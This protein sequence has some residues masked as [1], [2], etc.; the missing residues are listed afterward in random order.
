MVK[1]KTRM[2]V[3]WFKFNTL[4]MVLLQPLMVHAGSSHQ[5]CRELFVLLS[6]NIRYNKNVGLLDSHLCMLS[7]ILLTLTFLSKIFNHLGDISSCGNLGSFVLLYFFSIRWI[8]LMLKHT[9]VSRALNL[10]MLELYK[11]IKSMV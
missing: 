3:D 4:V 11:P 8:C 1:N 9:P 7:R 2:Q 10:S 6:L 5:V